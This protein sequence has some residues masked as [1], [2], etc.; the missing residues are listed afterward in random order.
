MCKKHIDDIADEKLSA[1][2]YTD[3]DALNNII[4]ELDNGNI[5]TACELCNEVKLYSR[6]LTKVEPELRELITKTRTELRDSIKYA[7]GLLCDVSYELYCSQH[8]KQLPIVG[9]LFELVRSFIEEFAKA[10]RDKNLLDF[11]DAEQ[12]MLSLLWEKKDGEYA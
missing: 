7:Y 8:Q 2:L 10:K 1:F 11:N 12:F 6:G 5:P 9:K 3:I 4:N